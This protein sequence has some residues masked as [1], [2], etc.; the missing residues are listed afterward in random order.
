MK[1]N[2][3]KL[4]ICACLFMFF[5]PA[6]GSGSLSRVATQLPKVSRRLPSGRPSETGYPSGR[7]GESATGGTRYPT[8]ESGAS[9][10]P[11]H[12]L[13]QP[14]EVQPTESQPTKPRSPFGIQPRLSTPWNKQSF[15][16]SVETIRPS[17]ESIYTT[18]RLKT[19]QELLAEQSTIRFCNDLL[20]IAK[21]PSLEIEEPRI[22]KLI[23]ALENG[24]PSFRNAQFLELAKDILYVKASAYENLLKEAS[25][26]DLITPETLE[27]YNASVLRIK[28]DQVADI[29]EANSIFQ[30]FSKLE[31]DIIQK[32]QDLEK[33]AQE[34]AEIAKQLELEAEAKRLEQLAKERAQL[35]KEQADEQTRKQAEE[36][37]RADE[38]AIDNL[39]ED[40]KKEQEVQTSQEFEKF[41]DQLLQEEKEIDAKIEAERKEIEKQFA[42]EQAEIE[43]QAKEQL[44]TMDKNYNLRIAHAKELLEKDKTFIKLDAEKQKKVIETIEK[45]QSQNFE[46]VRKSIAEKKDKRIAEIE[47]KHS[48]EIQ[49]LETE[50]QLALEKAK[51]GAIVRSQQLEQSSIEAL[52]TKRD[53]L[54]AEQQAAKA[55]QD[56]ETAQLKADQ[57]KLQADK[58]TQDRQQEYR[59]VE[60]QYELELQQAEQKLTTAQANHRTAKQQHEQAQMELEKT[61]KEQK[62]AL[63]AALKE[64]QKTAKKIAQPTEPTS[65]LA[66]K[67]TEP[68]L[69]KKISPVEKPEFPLKAEQ[70]KET[71]RKNL[72]TA[73][74]QKLE[75]EIKIADK[76]A[77][78]ELIDNKT[79]E[80]KKEAESTQKS[81]DFKELER[82]ELENLMQKLEQQ[83]NE[84]K[85]KLAQEQEIADNLKEQDRLKTEAAKVFSELE[86][87]TTKQAE[88]LTQQQKDLTKKEAAE[89]TL[90]KELDELT[91]EEAKLE[92][93]GRKRL[94]EKEKNEKEKE[95][96]K[97]LSELPGGG[98]GKLPEKEAPIPEKL[99]VEIPTPPQEQQEQ[100]PNQPEQIPL[101]PQ[102]PQQIEPSEPESTEMVEVVPPIEEKETTPNHT[103]KPPQQPASAEYR[104]QPRIKPTQPTEAKTEAV[105]PTSS[106]QPEQLHGT[107]FPLFGFPEQKTAPYHEPIKPQGTWTTSNTTPSS[108][109]GASTSSSSGDWPTYEQPQVYPE[110]KSEPVAQAKPK[111]RKLSSKAQ[112]FFEKFLA[113]EEP[114]VA[115]RE[116][117]EGKEI[118]GFIKGLR[119]LQK[120]QQV[121]VKKPI[122]TTE[123][124]PVAVKKINPVLSVVK[125]VTTTIATVINNV[126]DTIGSYINRL[127]RSNTST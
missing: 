45:N 40:F 58:A 101:L 116:A 11:F 104:Q 71:T 95:E 15:K 63:E 72:E 93:I 20:E 25:S 8:G 50:E 126:I 44:K 78:L 21:D 82:Q 110:K 55:Q 17:L 43:A 31:K 90:K 68:E 112:E 99:L 70:A 117:A 6:H 2:I 60:A 65:A 10:A 29:Q 16:P 120:K 77:A 49:K 98:D 12:P 107:E 83:A 85:E 32:Q 33:I 79:A 23:Y 22:T 114:V 35:E 100:A 9:T 61:I 111:A 84:L 38:Q 46:G 124:S 74:K 52:A 102:I 36:K 87:L 113:K 51:A 121:S 14:I 47:E 30:T 54:E 26:I 53:A 122:T 37:T 108:Y 57:A 96:I 28:G 80:V 64:T 3:I 73:Q 106:G 115:K 94:A 119:L 123:K 75:T 81:I 69:T 19:P 97:R 48:Q 13:Y 91:Q 88:N 4:A 41:K 103:P 127:F 56:F 125:Q 7:L 1:K 118:G 86:Q 34:K 67:I 76:T 105:M 5:T 18:S 27:T 92:E 24:P 89:D 66:K 42:K 39:L 59:A 109:S 62:E